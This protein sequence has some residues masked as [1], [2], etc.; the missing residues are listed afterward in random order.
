MLAR[1]LLARR[2]LS[3]SSDQIFLARR[4]LSTSTRLTKGHSKWQNIQKD[5]QAGDAARSKAI[6]IFMS[7]IRTAVNQNGGLDV[8][9]NKSLA[10]VLKEYKAESLPMDTWNRCLQRLKDK[11]EQTHYFDVIGPS[12][13]FF[14]V[15]TLTDSKTRMD[16]TLRKYMNNVG[17]FRHANGTILSTFNETGV[18]LVSSK[19]SDGSP[20]EMDT[21]EAL[22][23][24]MDCEDLAVIEEEDGDKW[25][26]IC[27]VLRLQTVSSRL[28]ELGYSVECAEVQWRSKHTVT[29]NQ[30]DAVKVE[31][32]YRLLQQDGD[33]KQIFD[34]LEPETGEE[35][36]QASEGRSSM[37]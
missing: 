26:L 7:K 3:T 21:L 28:V 29:L 17:H 31:R 19:R 11:P 13:S 27:P 37:V 9:L 34:N 24:D 22:C 20:V 14:V 8:R 32:F 1:A 5:K 16:N 6:N 15:E 33:I 23:V 2:C 30:D 25:E 35:E 12:G 18:L 10:N 4:C 36:M